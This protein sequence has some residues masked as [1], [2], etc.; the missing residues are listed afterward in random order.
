MLYVYICHY[1]KLSKRREHILKELDNLDDDVVV[2]KF[3]EDFDKEVISAEVDKK[4]FF[5]CHF[6]I[7]T[8]LQKK[9]CQYYTK[10][11]PRA[12]TMGEKSL[13]LK[14][15]KALKNIVA[16]DIDYA[17]IIEDDC[18]IV[19]NFIDKL[20]HILDNLPD[21]WD[22][23]FPNSQRGK[24]IY[25]ASGVKI[26]VANALLFKK[27]HPSTQG[28]YSYL[29]SKK[30]CERIVNHIVNNKI[31]L[32]MDFEY[33]WIFYTLNLNVY[34]NNKEPLI[35]HGDFKSTVH[36]QQ[37]IIR[38]KDLVVN[39]AVM[40]YIPRVRQRVPIVSTKTHIRGVIGT[41]IHGVYPPPR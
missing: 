38:A 31:V 20:K 27:K 17:L 30:C 4:Y 2:V 1:T 3:I 12:L 40:R 19:P 39:P 26:D 22:V 25:D 35:M 23:Y 6:N 14:H 10:W 21:D 13:T 11:K 24:E 29:I 28:T 41:L 18:V 33:N 32:P 37:R 34:F 36:P 8:D 16:T 9:R 7:H 5:P 15:Y